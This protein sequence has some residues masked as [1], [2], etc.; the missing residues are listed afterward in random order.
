MPEYIRIAGERGEGRGERGEERGGR[1]E[2]ERQREEGREGVRGEGGRGEGGEGEEE[3]ETYSHVG[4]E[5]ISG[6]GWGP[7]VHVSTHSYP[8]RLSVIYCNRVMD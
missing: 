1:G 4:N 8:S 5:A 2:R 7:L 3:R 6:T